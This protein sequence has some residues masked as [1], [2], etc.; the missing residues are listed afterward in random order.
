MMKIINLIFLIVLVLVGLS[1]SVLN[2]DPVLLNYY[3]GSSQLTLATTVAI[4]LA[5]GA[6]LGLLG[7]LTKVL[8]LQRENAKLKRSVKS[9]ERDLHQLQAI[10]AKENH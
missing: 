9:A 10:P 6:L 8:K 7:G 3:F 4:A 5:I 2:S 1:F